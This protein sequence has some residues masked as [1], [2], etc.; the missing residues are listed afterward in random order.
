MEQSPKLYTPAVVFARMQD[1]KAKQ[2]VLKK[3]FSMDEFYDSVV[4]QDRWNLVYI[5]FLL[6]G[7]ALLGK[8]KIFKTR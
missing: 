7:G 6:M 8:Y 3:N 4:P 5:I 1:G 2:K